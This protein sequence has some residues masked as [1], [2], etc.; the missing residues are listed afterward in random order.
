[1]KKRVTKIAENRGRTFKFYQRSGRTF[2]RSQICRRPFLLLRF[3]DNW[4]V[5]AGSEQEK[6]V[7]YFSLAPIDRGK[8]GWTNAAREAGEGGDG[9]SYFARLKWWLKGPTLLGDRP[10]GIIIIPRCW[11]W[12]MKGRVNGG[13]VSS[14]ATMEIPSSK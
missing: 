13:I 5:R 4:N 11:E 1:M 7:G 6:F 10:R 2:L 8:V 3:Q 12:R 14:N 9:I